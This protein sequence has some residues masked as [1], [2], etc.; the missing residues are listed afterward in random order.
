MKVSI[1]LDPSIDE[2]EILIR[3][4]QLTEEIAQLQE[5][6]LKQ[7]LAPLAFYKDRSEYFLDL[8][9]L[10]FLKQ[11]ERGFM[12][13]PRTRLMRSNRRAASDCL[14]SDFQINHCQHRADLFFRELFFRDQ[15]S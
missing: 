15:H 5:S 7:K 4:P 9:T 2:P 8:E 6:I 10:L 3:A 14:L 12:G 11:M 1:A 13:I